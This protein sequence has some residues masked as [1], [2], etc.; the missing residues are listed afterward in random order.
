[1]LLL[2]GLLVAGLLPQ[3]IHASNL[4]RVD[5]LLVTRGLCSSRAVRLPALP[6]CDRPPPYR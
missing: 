6:N 4:V 3:L 2:K 5:A 1:M